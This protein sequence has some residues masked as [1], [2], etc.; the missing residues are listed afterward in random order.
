[1]TAIVSLTPQTAHAAPHAPNLRVTISAN[2]TSVDPGDVVRYTIR[3][4]CASL[5][6][7]CLNAQIVSTVPSGM[8]IGQYT[9]SGGLISAVN[10]VGNTIT[11]SLQSPGSPAG[12]LDAGSTGLIKIRTSFATC[13][14]SSNPGSFTNSVDFTATGASTA[15]DSVD[16][17]LTSSNLV[18]CP[19]APPA[20]VDL[21][22]DVD[23]SVVQL[24]GHGAWDIDVPSSSSVYTF[25]DDFPDVGIVTNLRHTSVELHVQCGSEEG[26]STWHDLSSHNTVQDWYRDLGGVLPGQCVTTE[27]WAGYV[28]Y[29]ITNA[30]WVIP[31]NTSFTIHQA[32]N[33]IYL[34]SN[35]FTAAQ[36]PNWTEPSVGEYVTN[37]IIS[38]DTSM[39]DSGQS[40]DRHLLVTPVGPDALVTKEIASAPD[41]NPDVDPFDGNHIQSVAR[42]P[43][44]IPPIDRGPADIVY[45]TQLGLREPGTGNWEDPILYDLLPAELEYVPYEEGGAN[46]WTLFAPTWHANIPTGWPPEADPFN[47]PACMNPTFTHTSNWNGTGRTLLKWDFTGCTLYPVTVNYMR[48][49]MLFSV[50]IVAGTPANTV[51]TNI[52]HYGVAGEWTPYNC[53]G[54]IVTDTLDYDSDGNTSEILCESYTVDYTVP[55]MIDLQ[56]AKWV[57]GALDGDQTLSNLDL[58]SGYSRYSLYGDT[59]TDGTG[60]YQL[61]IEN[62]GNVTV[63]QLDVADFLPHSGDTDTLGVLGARLSDWA[64]QLSSDITIDRSSDDGATWTT[65]PAADLL[66]GAAM[67]ANSTNPCRFSVAN[68]DLDVTG[69]FP[70][71]CTAL[72]TGTAAGNLSFGF[73]FQPVTAFAPGELLRITVPVELNGNPPGCDDPACAG[74]TI[75][76]AAIAW[77]SF[78]FGGI[79]SDGGSQPLLDTEPIKVGLRMIDT[80]NFTSL[81]NYVWDDADGDGVQDDTEQPLV[82]VTVNLYNA[83]GDTLLQTTQTGPD[84]FYR[85]DGLTASTTYVIKLDNAS[86]YSAG[87]L[88][89]YRLTQVDAGANDALDS[90]AVYGADRYPVITA[91]VGI[92]TGSENAADP[93]EYP[94]N[95]FGL[96]QSA[97]LGDTIWYDTDSFGDQNEPYYVENVLVTLWSAGTDNTVGGGDDVQ[98]QTGPDGIL[99]NA[100]D[101]TTA[102]ATWSDGKYEFSNLPAGAYYVRFDASAITGTAPMTTTAVVPAGWTWTL[103][104]ATG[105]DTN[106]SDVNSTSYSPAVYLAAG[107]HNPTIDAGLKPIPTPASPVSIGNFVWEDTTANSQQDVGELGVPNVRV[108]LLDSGGSVIDTTFTDGDGFY[109]FDNLEDG[110]TYELIFTPPSGYTLVTANAA[111]DTVDSDADTTTGSTGTFTV[112]PGADGSVDTLDERW[113]AGVVG[114]LS[115]GNLVWSDANNNGLFDSGE[116]PM[117]GLNVNL[118]SVCGGAVITSTTTDSNGKYL[119]TNLSATTYVVEV[120]LPNNALSSTDIASS[121]NPDNGTDGDDN[122]VD[123]NTHAGYVCSNAITLELGGGDW[124]E[125]DHGQSVNGVTDTTINRNADYTLDF[126]LVPLVQIGDR[127]WREDDGDGLYGNDATDAALSGVVVTAISSGGVSYSDTTNGAGFYTIT[128]PVN[129]TY[130]VTVATPSNYTDSTVV[131]TGPDSNPNANNDE[132][133]DAT[134]AVVIV[135]E[136]DN[137]TI[138]FAFTPLPVGFITLIKN[139]ESDNGTF[140]FSSNDADLAAVQLTTSGN[141]ASTLITKAV[142]TYTLTE[143]ALAGWALKSVAVSGDTDHGSSLTD[144]GIVLDL[145][146]SEHITATFTNWTSAVCDAND[147]SGSV[148][149]D[150]NSDGVRNSNEPGFSNVTVTAYDNNGLVAT[151]MVYPDGTYD[152]DDIFVGR[153]GD[154]AHLRLEFSGLPSWM[155][156]GV[157]GSNSSTTIQI[158]STATCNADLAVQNTAEYCQEN[159]QVA[160]SCFVNGDP[161]DNTDAQDALVRFEYD[162]TSASDSKLMIGDKEDVGSL[163]GLAYDAAN[164]RLFGASVLKR[165]VGMGPGGS[166]AIYV[167]NNVSAASSTPTEFYD[168]ADHAIDVGS[169][170]SNATRG[171]IGVAPTA[172]SHDPDVFTAIGKASLGDLELG[173]DGTT[174]YVTNLHDR[175]VYSIDTANTA[176]A[177]VALAALPDPGCNQ[178]VLRPWGL[179]MYNDT[180]YAG[181]VCSAENGGTAADLSA[182]V[183]AYSGVSWSTVATTT[184]DYPRQDAYPGYSSAWDPWHADFSSASSGGLTFFANPSPILSDIEFDDNGNMILGLM[185]RTA[186]QIGARNYSTNTL[187]TTTY[188]VVSGGDILQATP[189]GDGTFTVETITNASDEHYSGDQF[190]KVGEEHEETNFG[191]LAVLPGS[192]QVVMSALDPETTDSGGIYWLD[193]ALGTKDRVLELY[194]GANDETGTFG[195]AVG[196]GD[197]E[198]FC[199]AAPLEIGNYVWLDEDSD[200]IQDACESGIPSVM[201][202]L[203][204]IT[205]TVISTATTD[206]SGEY[207]FIDATDPRLSTT[208]S[209]TVPAHVGVVPTSTVVSGLLPNTGYSIRIDLSQ[210]AVSTYT[211]TSDNVVTTSTTLS[212]SVDS[213]AIEVSGAA[214]INMTTG[215]AGHNDHTF[216]FGFVPSAQVSIAVEKIRNTPDPVFPGATVTFTIRITNTGTTTITTLPLTDTYSAAYLTYLGATPTADT[217]GN[218]GQILWS[219]LTQNAPNGFGEDLGPNAA[220]D[221]EVAFVAALDTSALPNSWTINTAQAFTHTVTDTVRIFNPTNV[222]LASRDVTVE[223]DVVVLSWSTVDETEIVGFHVLRLDE[224][225]GVPVRLTSDADI[226]LA[227]GASTGADYRYEDVTGEVD[228][229]HHYILEMVMADGTRPLMDMGTSNHPSHVWMIY[230]PVLR[231]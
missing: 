165:H 39:G 122:G 150:Y 139:T 47:N 175:L 196:L 207:Y 107:E 215:A 66:N 179:K 152:F 177:P 67:Y 160:T 56:S 119:F 156:S 44:A 65:V 191:G 31:A 112:N 100:D 161:A 73:R 95:D 117:A 51:I 33:L 25:T 40:C 159:P 10:K 167:V 23:H 153:T 202:T 229:N 78:A 145:D 55:A 81:G 111:V 72:A 141:T 46:F 43:D 123:T 185:D 62:T 90:D 69:S 187:S 225:G 120:A 217:T 77:N 138:D 85:F 1:M 204:D 91:T 183:F 116:Q 184:L 11:W 133:H 74:D 16:V 18:S 174:L 231:K 162:D 26:T 198:L 102:F 115:L 164:D 34:P 178:G 146:E 216:D 228:A 87:P 186:M 118:V 109:Q 136:V 98:V 45:A 170:P 94:T 221:V 41:I 12:Q 53:G 114:T 140:D 61:F 147:L 155:Q 219:D 143:D 19:D 20:T 7:H 154:D 163:W 64:T 79:Y 176:A 142:G 173:S 144:S 17:A 32:V 214:I 218:T 49:Y 210:S 22:K 206:A 84:G 110:A 75:N 172:P 48:L 35:P 103:A 199:A 148:W 106:D 82:G 128:V 226:I 3:Y 68:S 80:D 200:G 220:F 181:A 9:R 13:D 28:A 5:T 2:P 58:A 4:R 59:N 182:H 105:D 209:V 195:K 224:V 108:D 37:C 230:L 212:D 203:H 86:D 92:V 93:T 166:G 190:P 70:A 57:K 52:A 158:H 194:D 42:D 83:A 24:G 88:A 6:E 222:V 208:Y 168:F 29:N 71:G 60:T 213:D 36:L 130:T 223:D 135:E 97:S 89:G 125:S 14:G 211:L 21:V 193:N 192:G 127:V 15:S 157:Q 134:G 126:G 8:D 113:D 137:L 30:R 197:V 188:Y 38:S 151:A 131:F 180:L 76:N 121:A 169:I 104:S 27:L 99:G 54:D 124:D 63:T 50:R 189:D 201:V 227:Q 132:N 171:L 149:R 129:D 205:G 96:W 101:S